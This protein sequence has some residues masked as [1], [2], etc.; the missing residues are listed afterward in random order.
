MQ[1]E[2]GHV[3][4]V[5]RTDNATRGGPPGTSRGHALAQP[6][7][8]TA[9]YLKLKIHSKVF[10]CCLNKNARLNSILYGRR[11]KKCGS[12]I[13]KPFKTVRAI[14]LDWFKFIS[15]GRTKKTSSSPP[16]HPL[17]LTALTGRGSH[18]DGVARRCHCT[19]PLPAN[20]CQ[21]RKREATGAASGAGRSGAL[22]STSSAL[23]S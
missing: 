10:E 21:R 23:C 18:D 1:D 6:R 22:A 8:S 2:D 15:C 14:V 7:V 12:S 4:D 19:S 17:G 13:V 11:L 3:Q 9:V 16:R 20:G 5:R